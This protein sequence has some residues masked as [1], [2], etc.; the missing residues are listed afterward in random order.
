MTLSLVHV[1]PASG[2]VATLTATGGVAV[3]GY[4][5]H[6]WRG[7]GAC[8]TQGL[9]TN[10]WYPDGVRRRLEAGLE[11]EAA[12]RAVVDA[13]PG[14]SRRQCLV[15]AA[16]GTA[17]V[18]SGQD[19]LPRVAEVLR[20]TVAVAGNLLFDVS[21]AEALLRSFLTA[22][23]DN[24]GDVMTKG[25]FPA[26][27]DGYEARLLEVL[28]D[29]LEAALVAGGDVR[30]TYSVALRIESFQAAPLDLRVD[31]AE[32]DLIG[33]LRTLAD[34]V[35]APAFADFLASLPRR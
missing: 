7:L 30:G 25:A 3:G 20:P 26:Y 34:K 9:S 18:H 23:C 6:C 27:R 33:Q 8:V 35:R 28:I 17:A 32:H 10:P 5:P 31:W 13:D 21:V 16:Q 22:T 2:T 14:A 15:M 19:N 12:L 29:A 11:A 24:A 4:V 1:N